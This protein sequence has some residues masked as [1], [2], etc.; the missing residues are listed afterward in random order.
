MEVLSEHELS[1]DLFTYDMDLYI[2][3]GPG[4][5]F[6]EFFHVNDS[7]LQDQNWGNDLQA[8]EYSI[9]ITKVTT[10]LGEEPW[11]APSDEAK[12]WGSTVRWILGLGMMLPAIYL[13]YAMR[14]TRRDAARIGAMKQRLAMLTN[15]LDE[16]AESPEQTR[17]S[18]VRS[19]EA[20]AILP[21]ESAIASWGEP[22]RSY[23]TDGTSI[24]VWNL[25]SRLAKSL[26][27]GHSLLV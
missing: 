15:L 26:A 21:W 11:F 10:E 7:I 25:D 17:K 5:H 23:T 12:C 4:L 3:L 8:L 1:P 2:T 6:I 14:K 19:L 24:A 18:L 20:V 27:I 9:D 22:Q 13:V 16:G